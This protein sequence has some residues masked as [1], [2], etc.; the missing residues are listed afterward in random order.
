MTL[1]LSLIPVLMRVDVFS[2]VVY[3][4]VIWM[5]LY[6]GNARGF[7]DKYKWWDRAVHFLAGVAFV[8][9]GIVIAG[10]MTGNVKLGLLLFGFTFSL[11]LYVFWE[12]LEYIG[13][14]LFHFNAQRWQKVH[15]SN[16]HKS[17]KAMQPAG[18]VDTMSDCICCIIGSAMIVV[19]WWL[20]L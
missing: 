6:F 9:F 15:A 2:T 7:Y 3:F 12:L 11:T 18:L 8:G 20:L 14:C 16:N 5:A 13:D 1:A 17:K 19:V 10:E 4:A